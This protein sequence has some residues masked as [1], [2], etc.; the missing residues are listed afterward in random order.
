MNFSKS[1]VA[2]SSK[3]CDIDGGETRTACENLIPK[4]DTLLEMV[5]E[6]RLEQFLKAYEP[7]SVTLPGMVTEV[8]LIQP[9]KAN[10]SIFV[11]LLGI[12]TEVRA[13]QPLKA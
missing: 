11:T 5:T 1:N 7:M 12:E 4:S 3:V 6:E 8:R 2:P 13:T 9:L 10:P